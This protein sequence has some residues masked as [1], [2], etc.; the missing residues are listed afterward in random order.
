VNFLWDSITSKIS[1]A[2]QKFSIII[3]GSS[4]SEDSRWL[5]IL[6]LVGVLT[7]A[8]LVVSGLSAFFLTLR[9]EEQTM[10]PDIRHMDLVDALIRLQEKDLYPHVQ[11]RF[12]SDPAL[13][14]KVIDQ[15]PAAGSV[16]KAG[17]R[18]TLVVSQGSVV[19]KVENFA[20]KNLDDVRTH[21]QTLFATYKPLLRIKEPVTYIFDKAP[22]GTILEQQPAA[23]TDLTG[24]T[25]LTLIVSRG[26]ETSGTTLISYVGIDFNQAISIL[27]KGNIPFLFT[28]AEQD[29]GQTRQFTVISQTPPPGTKAGDDLRL[30]LVIAPPAKTSD[31]QVFGLFQCTLPKYPVWVD[32]KFEAVNI[33]GDRTVIF[34]MKHPGGPVSIP[35]YQEAN[36]TL[37][38]SV[39]NQEVYRD[40]VVSN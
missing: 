31:K 15:Q 16:V 34:T 21:I 17:K 4:E 27:A 33:S 26:P 3:F 12:S 20:G 29:S 7:V 38:L 1:S 13:K 35:Y 6:V 5:R 14:G 24:L 22:A 30:E 25:D 36:T 11:M 23:G 8:L 37:V 40:T 39:F 2:A 28:V 9:G 32:L 19:D 18:V 10:I